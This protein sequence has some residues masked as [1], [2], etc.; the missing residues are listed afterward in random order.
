MNYKDNRIDIGGHRFFSKSD[1]VMQ[2]WQNILPLQGAPSKDHLLMIEKFTDTK[3]ISQISK[4]G[5]DPN[6]ND[7]V[8]LIRQRIS[9]ILYLRKFFNYP[10]S[11]SIQTVRN[12]GVVRLIFIL[13]SYL[14]IKIFPIKQ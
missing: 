9:R 3:L 6:L 13:I 4:D 11:L 14:K 1:V 7:R 12:L 2:W 5:P 8:M 10:V